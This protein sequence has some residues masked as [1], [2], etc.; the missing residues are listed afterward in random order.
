MFLLSKR[1]R[2]HPPSHPH[3]LYDCADGHMFILYTYLTHVARLTEESIPLVETQPLTFL[4]ISSQLVI[5]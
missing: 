2:W 4:K 3:E 1:L 5:Y